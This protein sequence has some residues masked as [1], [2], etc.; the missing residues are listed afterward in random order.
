MAMV[1]AGDFLGIVVCFVIRAVHGLDLQRGILDQLDQFL[2]HID[3][4]PML[5]FLQAVARSPAFEK[6]QTGSL[7]SLPHFVKRLVQKAGIMILDPVAAIKE[8]L[9]A[10]EQS[11]DVKDEQ[12]TFC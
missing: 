3:P 10:V 8:V 6:M 4:L 11:G 12:P 7:P 9:H 2:H 1:D 5:F